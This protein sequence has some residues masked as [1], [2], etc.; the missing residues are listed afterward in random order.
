M[1]F[2]IDTVHVLGIYLG[3]LNN[4]PCSDMS[5]SRAVIDGGTLR[6]IAEPFKRE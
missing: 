5:V 3:W 4:R 6:F 2:I 1:G